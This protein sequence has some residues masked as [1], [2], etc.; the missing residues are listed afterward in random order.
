MMRAPS[1]AWLLLLALLLARP[2]VAQSLPPLRINTVV[3]AAAN[4]QFPDE[5]G[6]YPAYI[7][8]QAVQTT[9]LSGHF[10][11]PNAQTPGVWQF[12]AG[13]TLTSGQTIRVFASGKDRR[14][15]GP[16]GRLHTSFAY[17]CTV[18]F[19]GLHDPQLRFVHSFS[20]PIDH[21]A[22]EGLPLIKGRMMA[23]VLIP[24]TD[25][26][27]AW[28]LP[29]YDDSK[30]HRGP[31]GIGY[32]AGPSPFRNGL[33][34]YHT[35]DKQHVQGDRVP[36]LSGPILHDGISGGNP[37][38][39]PGRV[40]EAFE[41]KGDGTSYVRVPNHTELD[42]G[43]GSFSVAVWLRP[44]RG[45]GTAA[46]NT[47]SEM[48]V[49]KLGPAQ[50]GSQEPSGWAITRNQGGT[51]VGTMSA[52]GARSV[53]LGIT[54]ANQWHH[55]ALVVQR[56]TGQIIGFLNGKR[57]GT[58]ALPAPAQAIA[59]LADL[60]E[61]RD[62]IGA[63]PY[64]GLLDELAV[65]SRALTDDEVGRLFEIGQQGVSFLDP[66]AV[67]GGSSLYA[68][69]IGTDVLSRMRGINSTAYIRLPFNVPAIPAIAV[70]LRLRVHYDDGFVLHLN[71]AEVARRN[72]PAEVDYLSGSVSERPDTAALSGEWIDLSSYIGLLKPGGNVLSFHA[73][74]HG[75]DDE[76]FLLAPTQLCL[77]VLRTPP[78]G[79]DCVRETNGR[80]F[81]ITFPEN[82][83]QEPDTPLHLSLC[84]AGLPQTL[85]IIEIPGL[86]VPGFPRPFTI[87]PSGTLRVELPRAAELSGQD[88]HERKGIHIVANARVAVYGTTRMDYTTDTFLALPTPCL[89]LQYLV[90][91]FK[92]VFN[93]I[94]VLN[95]SQFAI[96]AV[97]NGTE[98]TITPS[99]QVG[100]HPAGVP[101]VVKLAR[102]ET[103]QLRQEAG[104][105]ADITGTRIVS[106][107]PIGVF[108]SHRC[109]NIESV[110][111]FFCD[112]VVEQ[113]L[114]VDLW[115]STFF[116]VP[117]A[118]RKSDTLRVLS[119]ADANLVT[120]VTAAGSQ[121]FNLQRGEH[122][123][124]I[125]DLPTRINC[126]APSF[127]TQFSNS[128][129]ADNV[130][131]ADP[132]MTLIQPVGT[133]LSQ[134]RFCTPAAEDFAANYIHLIGPSASVLDI[135]TING[136]PLAAWNP[137]DVVR[138]ALPTGFAFA[139]V[140][141]QAATSYFVA[142]QTALGMIAYGF[143]EFDSYGYPGGMR[144]EGLNAPHLVCFPDITVDCQQVAGATGCLGLVPDLTL[145]A[146]VYD[147]C[148]ER[149]KVVL[150]QTP[151]PGTPL[152]PGTHPIELIA[153]DVTGQSSGCVTWLTV[154]SSWASQRFGPAVV[155]NPALEATVWG[156]L[157][158]PDQDGLPN[159]LEEAV[160]SDPNQRSPLHQVL[161]LTTETDPW[162]TFP[163]VAI[164]RLVHDQGPAVEIEGSSALSQGPW[165]SGPD[166][167]E[168]LPDRKA[169]LSFGRHERVFF[170]VRYPVGNTISNNAYFLRLRLRE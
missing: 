55:V 117:L 15:V 78:T 106:N 127:V 28:T 122:R 99:S 58:A 130:V 40:A 75:T 45:G 133:W 103:Y 113:L 20:D 135:A 49:S 93:G 101:Y 128:S 7:E 81:W 148:G 33:V 95:G 4:S 17:D 8:I 13:Y 149:G 61:G 162:G 166:I 69:Y 105:P 64:M 56:A 150:R 52:A 34:L 137:A 25:L 140:R 42:P 47:F 100:T 145:R 26:G 88:S 136:T 48:L 115:G 31:V 32:D 38:M 77:E 169:P 131:N 18:P 161:S 65:W 83:V 46:G 98:V 66:A 144:F 60:A 134:Y 87:P 96:V 91:S 10:L 109:A 102:G 73:L 71:G 94:P 147:G 16:G 68:P 21:C 151:P 29:G 146:E 141:L 121:S 158:D 152:P 41:F 156:A 119:S 132:F 44:G 9:V 54:P 1:M 50:A 86:N 43:T 160:G 84:I 124:L 30:W 80:D 85:G 59:T 23:R 157:A 154:Q 110:N 24:D 72:A 53:A 111:Q 142:G 3:P 108:G 139:R 164:P 37:P 112:T 143:S 125:L 97:A 126:R 82:Y 138:G 39:V 116:V 155:A 123:D 79:D 120:V 35:F 129:D 163:I 6:D 167:L 51:F 165:L 92:N 62:L 70:G 118:T 14:P 170:K 90:S 104:Q 27:V 67:P 89:G 74:N 2:A 19:C 168:E 11:S 63:V 57:I 153:T 36:D 114:P 107:K 76:R 159:A 12:P 5:D 22:C